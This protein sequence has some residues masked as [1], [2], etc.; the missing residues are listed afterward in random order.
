M[1]TIFDDPRAIVAWGPPN[2]C[3]ATAV[4]GGYRISGEWHF[5]SGCRQATWMGA[6][7]QVVEPDGSLRLNAAGRPTM[8]TLL[9]PAEHATHVTNWNTIGMRGTA[10]EGYR[11]TTCSCRRH[12]AAPARI[13]R[14]GA[15]PGRLYAFPQQGAVSGR[16]RRRGVRHRAR[17]AR[18]V[19]RT[20]D[21]QDAAR[22]GAAGGQCRGAEQCRAHARRGSMRA[23]PTLVETLTDVWAT[24]DD[25]GVIDIA[26]ARA[27]AAGL[28]AR[29]PRGDRGGGLHLQG[30]RHGRD[31]PGHAVRA[32]VPRHAHAVAADPVARRALRSR[33]PHYCCGIEPEGSFY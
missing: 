10:S 25:I 6:H 14:C 26:G 16:R 3:K 9:F 30:G 17:H 18:R 4:P 5:A 19:H 32:P 12:S 15:T 7:G 13:R 22:P 2:A 24:A 20:G 33:R 11:W 23:A 8:R 27:R 31:L 28:R 29:D 21:A 1:H